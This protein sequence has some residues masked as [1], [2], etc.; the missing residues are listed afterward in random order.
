MYGWAAGIGEEKSVTQR[1]RATEAQR[2]NSMQGREE[3]IPKGGFA[4]GEGWE[5]G[6]GIRK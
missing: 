1:S 6:M 5:I 3:A 4:K 2:K